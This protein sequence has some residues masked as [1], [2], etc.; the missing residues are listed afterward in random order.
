MKFTKG[1]KVKIVRTLDITFDDGYIFN[2]YDDC[3][4]DIVEI[5]SLLFPEEIIKDDYWYIA[6]NKD[7]KFELYVPESIIEK[8]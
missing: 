2:G 6:I 8:I 3:Q 1:D 7:K 5:K 4:G